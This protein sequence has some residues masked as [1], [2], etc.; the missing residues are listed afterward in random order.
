M[1]TLELIK[2]RVSLRKYQDKPLSKEHFDIILESAMRAPTAG[3][4][5]L[6]SI[7]VIE[8]EEKKK[9]LSKTCDNQPFIANAPAV[10]IFLADMQRW[11]DYYN[12]C[13]VKEYCQE[14][15]LEYRAPDVGDLMLAS[16][17]AI[18][19]AQ[20][21]VIAGEALNIGSCYIGDII[22]NWEIHREAL[23]LPN[24]VFPAAMLCMGYYPED[25][26]RVVKP[27]FDKDY[28]VFKD[29]YKRLSDEELKDMFS[30]RQSNLSPENKFKAE[31]IGQFNYAAKTG[32]EF[33]KEM[34]RS[35]REMLKNWTGEHI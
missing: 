15:N 19:A 18:I 27:R 28:I 13:G 10:L 25:S 33:S 1:E 35:V 23:S 3:N 20:N 5:M 26:K 6:Y 32:A 7:I 14:N 12:Y 30:K 34:T 21:A 4:M 24:W 29:E 17:D 9:L 31:N 8:D 11:Y 22:E 2:N 16:A